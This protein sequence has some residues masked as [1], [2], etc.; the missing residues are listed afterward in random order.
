ML[1]HIKSFKVWRD[2][3]NWLHVDAGLACEL[4]VYAGDK[5]STRVIKGVDDGVFAEE[6]KLTPFM[7]DVPICK[8]VV[9]DHLYVDRD[10]FEAYNRECNTQDYRQQE[11]DYVNPS[12][13]QP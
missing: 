13:N 3:V 11:T 5:G 8:R 9:G 6:R 1:V 7:L 12:I 2:F 10:L 4:T